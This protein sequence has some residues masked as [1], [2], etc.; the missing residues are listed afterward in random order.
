MDAPSSNS[1]GIIENAHEFLAAEHR[2]DA[3]RSGLTDEILVALQIESVRPQDLTVPGAASAYRIPY[4][5]MDGTRNYFER[6]RYL[7]LQHT[8]V[9]P[10]LWASRQ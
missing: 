2:A 1:R 8:G 7:F 3:A 4:F 9:F 5:T 10:I 6:W